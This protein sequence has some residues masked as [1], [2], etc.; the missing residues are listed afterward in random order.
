MLEQ[1][2]SNP[3]VPSLIR[4]NALLCKVEYM[5]ASTQQH[6]SDAYR[7]ILN[8]SGALFIQISHAYRSDAIRAKLLEHGLCEGG[9]T[10]WTEELFTIKGE[11]E[12]HG[13]WTEAISCV[14]GIIELSARES[15]GVDHSFL[16]VE[17]SLQSIR[18]RCQNTINWTAI[19]LRNYMLWLQG[20]GNVG[21]TLR[22]LKSL[23]TDF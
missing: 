23:S 11:L 22:D 19:S 6:P 15:F 2:L 17:R 20:G 8:E 7:Q 3:N 10:Q 21:A 14:K 9:L 4:A 16:R 13:G 18:N 1:V 5:L 12:A